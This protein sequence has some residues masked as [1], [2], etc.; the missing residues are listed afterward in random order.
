MPKMPT[1]EAVRKKALP[2]PVTDRALQHPPA[3]RTPRDAMSGGIDN[4]FFMATA[5][6]GFVPWG[7]RIKTRDAQ[8]RQFAPT[9]S[10]FLSALGIVSARNAAFAW[11]ID[12]PERT[13]KKYREILAQAD[14]GQG[15]Q[16]MISRITIDLSTQDSGAY[17]ELIRAGEGP[18]S[19]L[20]GIASMDAARCWP[21][22]IPEVPVLYM[23]QDSKWHEVPWW[24][25]VHLLEMPA[26]IESVPGIQYCALTRMLAAAR[27]LRDITTYLTEK[28]GGRHTKAVVALRG[29]TAQDVQDAI[30]IAASQADSVGLTH[31]SLPVLVSSVDPE[32]QVEMKM[33]DL[34]SLPDGFKIE[35]SNKQYIAQMAMAFLTDYQEFAPLPGG[36]LGTSNQSQILHDKSRGKGSG[37]FRQIVESALN[38]NV[39]PDNLTFEFDEQD[40]DQDRTKAEIA[41]VRAANRAARLASGELDIPAARQIAYEDGDLSQEMLEALGQRSEEVSLEGEEQNVN[42]P[43]VILPEAQP[44]AAPGQPG[45]PKFAPGQP[46]AKPAVPLAKAP[47]VAAKEKDA[48]TPP[49]MRT[50]AESKIEDLLNEAF[51]HFLEKLPD[52]K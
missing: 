29:V 19:E 25:V 9:E 34:A 52:P 41:G 6:D 28:V 39:L 37:L 17:I 3:G 1:T 11:K 23:D 8:L 48:P 26:T 30:R 31:F 47:P 32:A 21:T 40:D 16:A 18:E 38:W 50:A 7:S 27:L 44:V 24:R 33:L 45:Q 22:G 42:A 2:R 20:I 49:A 15:W 13:A 43:A 51:A 35:E 4:V 12:G 10:M 46:G 36:G 5:S 14:F